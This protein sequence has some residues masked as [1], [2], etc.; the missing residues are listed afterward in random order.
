MRYGAA[1]L[2]L[3]LAMA[4]LLLFQVQPL[5]ANT[6]DDATLRPVDFDAEVLPI[7]SEH[8]FRCHGG[9]RE[10]NGLNLITRDRAT[11]VAKSGAFAIVPSHPESSEMIRRINLVGGAKQMPPATSALSAQQRALLERWIAEGAQW[12]KPWAM[13]EIRDEASP[14][15]R[16]ASWPREDLDAF[17]LAELERR[18]LEP[19][20]EADRQTL[21]RRVSLDLTGLPPE[22]EAVAAFLADEGDDAYER[23]VDGLLASPHYGE[24]WARLWLDLAR[25]ADTQGYE[26]D[27]PRTMWLW[28]DW[29]ID[30]LNADMP[31]DEFSLRL[32]AGD[33]LEDATEGD[34]IA[35][36]FHRNTLTNTEGGTDDE[37]FRIAAVMD[38]VATTWQAWMG[39]TFQCTQCH[40]HPFEPYAHREYYEFLAFFNQTADVDRDDDA[41]ILKAKSAQFGET[42][43]LVMQELPAEQARK[44]HLFLRGSRVAPAEEVTANTPS[45]LPA[46]DASLPRNRL[47]LARWLFDPKHPLTA[48][49]AA[50]RQWETLF[51]RGIVESSEDFSLHPQVPELLGHLATRLRAL[52]FSMKA[53]TREIVLSATY[54]QS[55]V[56]SATTLAR[57]PDNRF[58]SRAIKRR[59]EAETVRDASLAVGG[60]LTRTM[61]GPPVM[62][63]QPPGVWATVYSGENWKVSEGGDATR[64]SIY[65]YWKRT[66]PHPQMLALD[67]PS[68]ETCTVRRT[69]TNTPIATLA[70]FNDPAMLDAAGGLARRAL[71]EEHA[72]TRAR[73]A[74]MFNVALS[75]GASSQELDRLDAFV[76]G[77]RER[78]ATDTTARDAFLAALRTPDGTLDLSEYAALTS[79]ANL[80]LNLDEFLTTK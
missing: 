68:R 66:S 75:R 36:A 78:F 19:A 46:M 54:R 6:V 50:N 62:P 10:M 65:T 44:T 73:T 52:D 38:R 34:R 8:C 59:L 39:T 18:G 33:L 58:F 79:G 63:P 22:P 9:V 11:Q 7:I 43:V 80:I 56:A 20:P 77:E 74:Y 28:R 21:L 57:D 29:V 40:G 71:L 53:F 72:N 61:H 41:P 67:A 27:L 13:Q 15:V 64:R 47:G 45:V 25:Y 17:V 24:R 48:R 55:S 35:T 51:G 26:K 2:A 23:V 16:H 69:A 60:V 30:A 14:N 37:E 42:S 70:T 4:M 5:I 1:F 12:E 3:L 49:V 32:L 76:E 31:Y